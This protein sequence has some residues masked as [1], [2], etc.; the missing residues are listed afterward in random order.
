MSE[1]NAPI[2]APRS[3]TRRSFAGSTFSSACYTRKVF[4]SPNL[5]IAVSP[6]LLTHR[7]AKEGTST[8][9]RPG[10]V[11]QSH[12]ARGQKP[13]LTLAQSPHKRG[14]HSRELVCSEPLDHTTLCSRQLS[15][16]KHQSDSVVEQGRSPLSCSALAW[17]PAQPVR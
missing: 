16:P 17:A 9:G 10:H 7:G 5:S 14:L 11:P 15:W 6:S 4:S 8:T 1:T 2:G 12:E 3:G 13:R